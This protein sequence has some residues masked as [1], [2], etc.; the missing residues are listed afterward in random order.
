MQPLHQKLTLAFW[1]LTG[2]EILGQLSGFSLLHYITKPLLIPVL[3]VLLYF[4]EPT[5]PGK[6]LLMPA[7]LFSWLGD[8]FLLAENQAPVYFIPGLL[9]FLTTHVFYILFFLRSYPGQGSLL[10]KQPVL[11]LLIIAYGTGLV[12]ILFP[13]LGILKIPV[14]IYAGIICTM[15][16]CSLHA[17]TGISRPSNQ[18]YVLGAS[19]FVLSDSLLAINKFYQPFAFAGV[20]IMLTYCT[21]QYCMVRGFTMQKGSGN[22]EP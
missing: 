7:L 10:R 20:F 4:T 9:C 11:L 19:T 21:A 12:W 1:L 16:L 18:W 22:C 14:M 17:F 8:I 3:M 5:V 13:H 6:K 2:I 15:L